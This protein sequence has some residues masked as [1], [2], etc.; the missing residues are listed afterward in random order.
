MSGWMRPIGPVLV[1]QLAN[2]RTGRRREREVGR[3]NDPYINLQAPILAGF[4]PVSGNLDVVIGK[5][6]DF[7][8]R[9]PQLVGEKC[10]PD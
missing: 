6:N 8:A 10:G 7:H 2:M 1:N 5:L 3:N 9:L 4:D